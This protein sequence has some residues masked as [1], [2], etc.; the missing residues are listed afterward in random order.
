MYLNRRKAPYSV[1]DNQLKSW[2]DLGVE[3]VDKKE[4][5]YTLAHPGQVLNDLVNIYPVKI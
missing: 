5:F 2:Y 1:K 4:W 3:K